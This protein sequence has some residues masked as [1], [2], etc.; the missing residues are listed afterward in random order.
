[1]SRTLLRFSRGS[2][3]GNLLSSF[4]IILFFFAGLN[5]PL[6]AQLSFNQPSHIKTA[7]YSEAKWAA[8]GETIWLA[9]ELNST[10]GWHIY[11]RNYGETGMETVFTFNLPEGVKAGE[12]QWPYPEVLDA[13]DI[14]SFGYSG[15][16]YFLVP[17]TIDKSVK[18]GS[19]LLIKVHVSWLECRESCM[20]GE[21]E[22]EI[23]LPVK[24]APPEVDE[25]Y[26]QLFSQARFRI[27]HTLSDWQISSISTDHT[28]LLQL[29]PPEWFKGNL[30]E[31]YF[32]P[33]QQGVLE[34][35]AKQPFK[36]KGRSYLIE[37]KRSPQSE[38]PVDTLK[39]VLVAEPGWR[40]SGSEKG[41]E[42][43][44]PISEELPATPSTSG[45]SS[46][47]LAILFSFLGGMILNLMPCVL[48][49]LSIK[50]MRFVKQAQDEHTK[51]WKHGIVFTAGVLLT[52][53]ALAIVLLILKAGGE[54]LGWG[55]QL[56]SPTFLIIISAFMFLLGLSMFGVFE[57]G[58]SL[59][60]VGGRAGKSGGWTGSFMDGVVATVVAT[61]C[62][63]PF[64]GG[65]LGF[66]L[67]QPPLISL[68]I[69]TFLG[70]G[71]AFPFALLTSVPALLKFVPKPGRWMESLKQ[72]MGFLL[73]ATVIW[74][75][76]VLSQQVGTLVVII[77]LFDLMFTAMA[78][79][80]YGRWGNLAM[81]QK[82]RITA[83]VLAL[84][85]LL[86]SNG[87]TL[88]KYHHFITNP[89][90]SVN[91]GGIDWQPY[92]DELLNQLL[93]EGNPVFI[94]FTAKWCVSCQVNEQVALSSQKVAQKFRELGIIPLK[95]DWTKRD[96]VITQALARY[97]RM[98][99]PL[100]VLY[101]GRNG[102]Q[103]KILPEILTP[104]IVLDALEFVR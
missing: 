48:P 101:S 45:I 38:N 88:V 95:A 103:P 14:I 65:A 29:T 94:D 33:Y 59:T 87:Y 67:T 57:I 56:Q 24:D 93:K 68:V 85:I 23:R 84:I 32:F 4:L 97:G 81:P 91:A 40:G 28:Y 46:I 3:S 30:E 25:R 63:A 64:M 35:E 76:W 80:V 53:W 83:W 18:P 50:I 7:I 55:F 27:P 20:P 31:L 73:I 52:F 78:G 39:G 11:W 44:V 104:G 12:V 49:V 34:Y 86:F 9:V 5:S 89:S 75:L 69:F 54:Q 2:H 19:E 42:I 1:M 72:F 102:E 15:A 82:T 6:H 60:A 43:R 22:L 17:I 98:S 37:L 90:E 61:P 71:M 8:P 13:A 26:S 74:L 99:V 41:A 96:P 62:T 77:V 21:K 79:W 51:P 58:T 10:D 36:K 70:L 16:Q 47:W 92:S 100:Y 66:A